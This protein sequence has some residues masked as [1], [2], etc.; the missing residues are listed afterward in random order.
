Y[1]AMRRALETGSGFGGTV[2]F[3]PEEGKYHLDGHRACKIRLDPQETRQR[4]GLCPV[5]G[6]ALTVGVMHRVEELADRPEVD[7]GD[8]QPFRSLVPLPEIMSEL[9]SVGPGSKTVVQAVSRLVDRLG[10]ELDILQSL[11]LEDVAAAADPLTVEALSR[12]RSGKVHCE[13]G[14]DGEYGV[15]RMFE[16]GELDRRTAVAPLFEPPPQASRTQAQPR[17]PPAPTAPLKE[18]PPPAEDVLERSTRT[19]D[20]DLP[21]VAAQHGLFDRPLPEAAE[22]P[23]SVLDALDP[24]QRAAAE[25]GEGPLL[26]VAGPGT[27]KTRTLTH[28]LAYLIEERGVRPESCLAVTFT[29]RA[30]GEMR[31]R[32]RSLLPGREKGVEVTTFHGLGLSILRQNRDRLGLPTGF[33]IA[34]PRH[35]LKVLAKDLACAPSKAPALLA[36]LSRVRRD[37]E[38]GLLQEAPDPETQ[39]Q[40]SS[41]EEALWSSGQ[42]DFDDLLILPV[43]LFDREPEVA[44]GYRQQFRWIFVDEYQD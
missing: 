32:L 33:R 40:I 10:P 2:E 26:I 6:K 37:R 3:F 38:A 41:Y 17:K 8:R 5:C 27:G 42:V 39:Q 35:C 23:R 18:E 20:P 43:R 25:H 9:R 21:H 36:E 1:F 14:Y 11:P 16:P 30:A 31:D 24:L 22:E 12:L 19:A 13:A 29:R 4:E 15:I 7:S 34:D 28:R 44:E